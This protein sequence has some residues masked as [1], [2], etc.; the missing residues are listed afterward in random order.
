MTKK[1]VA[2]AITILIKHDLVSCKYLDMGFFYQVKK[3]EALLRLSM[4]RFVDIMAR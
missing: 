4:P 1:D 3:K 2:A